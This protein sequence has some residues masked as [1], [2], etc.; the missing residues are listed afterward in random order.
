MTNYHLNELHVCGNLRDRD[1]FHMMLAG[2][3]TI[4]KKHYINNSKDSLVT[5]RQ[6]YPNAIVYTEKYGPNRLI[7]VETRE[8][9]EDLN[10]AT[11]YKSEDIH[12]EK[13]IGDTTTSVYFFEAPYSLIEDLIES[14]SQQFPTLYFQLSVEFEDM[15]ITDCYQNGIHL[16]K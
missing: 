13:A 2:T 10:F 3:H 15:F 8:T 4:R 16:N 6:A 9:I 5:I 11:L 12:L 14:I 7:V 1:K